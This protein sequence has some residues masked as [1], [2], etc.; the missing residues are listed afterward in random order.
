MATLP[1]PLPP[2]SPT[3]EPSKKQ[4]L[5]LDAVDGVQGVPRDVVAHFPPGSHR[6]PIDE[7]AYVEADGGEMTF[8][9][10]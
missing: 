2:P 8:D 3:R 10:S 4:L 5:R 9:F 6:I 1:S 7:G